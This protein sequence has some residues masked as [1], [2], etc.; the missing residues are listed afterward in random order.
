MRILYVHG[1]NQVAETYGKYFASQGH[2]IHLYE[3]DLSGGNSILPLKL[4][5]MPAR[6]FDLRQ[7]VGRLDATYFDL[8]H[9]HWASY[10]IL[11]L[12][13]RIPYIVECH[14]SDVRYRLQQPFFRSLLTPILRRAAAVLCI[15]PDLL[16]VVQSIHSGA[17]FLPAPL[18][19][20]RFVP[21]EAENRLSSHIWTILLFARLCSTKGSETAIEGIRRFIRRHPHVCVRLLDWGSLRTEYKRRYGDRFEFVPPVASHEVEQLICSADVIVGQFALGALGISEL[22]AMSCAKPVICSFRYDDAYPTPPP[23]FR[24]STAEEIDAHLE[25]LYQHPEVGIALGKKS[26]EWVI[27]NHDYRVLAGRLEELYRTIIYHPA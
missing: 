21:V 20:E 13:S 10:G 27:A 19:I 25:N 6:L 3:P 5:L 24:A 26:R 17:L 12:V 23:L 8:A 18:D 4:A 7:V 11:G 16:P 14:G 9:I 2:L 15:T 1:I 22:Q